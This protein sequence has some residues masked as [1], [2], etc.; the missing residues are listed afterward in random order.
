MPVT[1]AIIQMK[2]NLV[3]DYLLFSVLSMAEYTFR[4]VPDHN[5]D[6]KRTDKSMC[7]NLTTNIRNHNQNSNLLFAQL[8]ALVLT[9]CQTYFIH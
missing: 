2:H 6:G 3:E 4:Q 5:T 9:T 7:Q 1:M 8:T